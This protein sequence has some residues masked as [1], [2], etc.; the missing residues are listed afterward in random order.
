MIHANRSIPRLDEPA[1]VLGLTILVSVQCKQCES[2]EAIGLINAQ[3]AVC[4]GCGAVI[5]V[6]AVRWAK[7]STAPQITLSASPSRA[8]ALIT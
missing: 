4:Q 2:E 3:P 1:T 6:D 8:T 5:S 7:G